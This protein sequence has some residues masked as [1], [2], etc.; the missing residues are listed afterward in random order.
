MIHED[1]FTMWMHS[2]RRIS[3][4]ELEQSS[5]LTRDVLRELV[6]LGALAPDDPGAAE[7][8]F[9]ADCVARLRA[10]ARITRDLELETPALALALSF[11]ERIERLQARLRELEA[12]QPRARR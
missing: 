4:V 9:A 5:G 3:I 11:L 10:A 8:Q 1:E 6:D 12:Q 2:Q 7:W